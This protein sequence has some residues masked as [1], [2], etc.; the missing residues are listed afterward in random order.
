MSNFVMPIR[1]NESEMTEMDILHKNLQMNFMWSDHFINKG[2]IIMFNKCQNDINNI[3]LRIK[4]LK[5]Q[6][7]NKT[8]YKQFK[9]N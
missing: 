5:Q 2:D 1:W 3:R 4:A 9:N 6:Q 8:N 7:P